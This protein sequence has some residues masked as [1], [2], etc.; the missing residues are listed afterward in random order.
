MKKRYSQVFIF[1]FAIVTMGLSNGKYLFAPAA[2]IFPILFMLSFDSDH[3]KRSSILL[4]IGLGLGNAIS[5]HGMLPDVGIAYLKILPFMAGSLMAPAFILQMYAF[6]RSSSY[7]MIFILP[8]LYALMDLLNAKLN[9]FGGFGLLGYSQ[10]SFL[11]LAQSASIL[12]A[13]GLTFLIMIFASSGFWLLKQDRFT[14]MNRA[15]AI[16]M[17]LIV[18][19]L[20]YGAIRL[21]LPDQSETYAVSGIHTLDRT[22]DETADLFSDYSTNPQRFIESSYENLSEI[23]S[24]TEKEAQLG[25]QLVSHAEATIVLSNENKE[26]GIERIRNT[27]KS[28]KIIIVTTLYVLNPPPQKNENLLMIINETGEV[29]LE[30]YKYGGNVFEG[31]VKGSEIIKVTTSS[32]GNLSGIICWDKDFPSIVAQA[33]R[34]NANTLFIPSADWEAL[35]PYHS[36]VGSFRG[37]ENGSNVVTQTV[38]GMSMIVDYKGR[39]VSEM[40]HFT[41]DD[42]VNRGVLPIRTSRTLY[43]HIEPYLG[44]LFLILFGFALYKMRV[45]NDNKGVI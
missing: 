13:I 12:G 18:M 4:F 21:T 39:V 31:S 2:F 11:P 9:P 32:V 43:P 16:Y 28:E 22:V 40:D 3:F 33:G 23:L 37:L 34:L 15:F 5:F 25:A 6:R 19:V 27:A 45:S 14:H 36:I 20:G 7:Q 17:G 1:I 29:V 42:W 8:C 35:S 38:N 41:N 24:K 44:Y 26:E 30:H 10:H